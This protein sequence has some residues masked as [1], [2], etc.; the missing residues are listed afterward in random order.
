MNAN[1]YNNKRCYINYLWYKKTHLNSFSFYVHVHLMITQLT[2]SLH[3]VYL[4]QVICY[5]CEAVIL[6]ML[7][8]FTLRFKVEEMWQSLAFNQ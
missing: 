3:T 6:K 7:L 2:Y 1:N 4:F 5:L 8:I